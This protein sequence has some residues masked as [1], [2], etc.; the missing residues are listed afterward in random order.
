MAM[1]SQKSLSRK[2]EANAARGHSV[3]RSS[4][5]DMSTINK[6]KSKFKSFP[7][8]LESNLKLSDKLAQVRLIMFFPITK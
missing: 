5:Q 1:P 6:A 4:F 2:A 8:A 7:T 3:R